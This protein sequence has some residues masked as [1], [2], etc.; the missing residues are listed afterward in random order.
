MT[1]DDVLMAAPTAASMKSGSDEDSP[2]K[3]YDVDH[4]LN[5]NDDDDGRSSQ[6]S[7]EDSDEDDED[8]NDGDD[9]DG[10]DDHGLSEYERMRLERIKRNNERLAA[11]GLSKENN[12]PRKPKKTT[13]KPRKK[14]LVDGPTRQLPGRAGRATFFESVIK[15]RERKDKEKE[16]EKNPDACFTCQSETGGEV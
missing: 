5:D 13:P 16:E 7:N 10:K 6:S 12:I 11:L 1:K 3:T 15:Q 4:A 2:L 14:L 8:D 9:E